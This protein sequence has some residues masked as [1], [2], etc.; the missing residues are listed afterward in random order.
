MDKMS[1]GMVRFR[2]K[3]TLEDAIELHA[4]APLEASMRVTNAIH[5]GCSLSY[6]LAL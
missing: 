2:L 4:F 5:L 3:F 6:R 1:L